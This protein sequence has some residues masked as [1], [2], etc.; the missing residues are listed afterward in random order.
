[1]CSAN[2]LRY[3]KFS[4]LE[5]IVLYYRL[6][7]KPCSTCYGTL[8]DIEIIITDIPEYSE[9]LPLSTISYITI[10]V[11]SVNNAPVIFVLD[12]DGTIIQHADRTDEIM[13]I[14][15]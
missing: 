15:N 5:Y 8:R 6:T 13:V 1:M 9:L 14:I 11:I 2:A 3:Q 4:Y 10:D 12:Y 7:F